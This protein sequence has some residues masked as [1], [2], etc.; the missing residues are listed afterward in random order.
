M[1]TTTLLSLLL[2]ISTG[3]AITTLSSDIAALKAIKSSI[4][5]T[6]IPSYTCLYSWDFTSDPC[7]PPHV[8]HF[9]C[10]LSCSGNRVT[11]LTF[12]SAG[13]VGTLSPL[14]SKLIQLITINLSD[15]K[16]SG[17]IPN[18]LFFLPN[19]QT[20]ILGS[21]SFSGGIPPSISNL[22]SIQTLDISRN[23]LSG[24]LPNTLASLTELTRLDLSFNKLTGP[25][26]KLPKNIIQLALKG[27][28]LNGFHQKQSFTELTQL[29]VVELS[30]TR[31]PERFPAGSSLYPPSS[32]SI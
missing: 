28:S 29:E 18:S 14:V 3:A 7:S 24:S 8:T 2:L 10:G 26:T 12:D 1:S 19:L 22:R 6:T 11:Q 27:N 5:P 21:N 17:A 32:K 16:F 31:S 15:D 9:L 30:E 20:L 4:K 13:Y 23:S 25:I